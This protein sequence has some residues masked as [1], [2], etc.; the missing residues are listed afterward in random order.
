MLKKGKGWR[1]E[2]IFNAEKSGKTSQREEKWKT[3]IK[4]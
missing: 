3:C 1:K 4:N 2:G